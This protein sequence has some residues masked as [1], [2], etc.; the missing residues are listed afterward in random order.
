M[1]IKQTFLIGELAG[2]R[3]FGPSKRKRE[4]RL[5]NWA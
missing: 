3:Q 1:G 5:Y 2:D 4:I